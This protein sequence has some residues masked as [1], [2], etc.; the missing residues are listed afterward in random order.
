P[1]LIYTDGSCLGNGAHHARAGIGIFFG[2]SDPRNM[3]ARLPGP[4]QTNNRAE[5]F[6]VIRAME[7]MLPPT[8]PCRPV[9]IFSDSSYMR[10]EFDEWMQ[11]W[12]WNGWITREGT[13][14]RNKDL[15][16]RLAELRN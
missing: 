13:D 3:S 2:P 16:L 6:A 12:I 10:P 5:G 14:V 15:C 4:V 8:P 7:I 11:G 1:I 9:I